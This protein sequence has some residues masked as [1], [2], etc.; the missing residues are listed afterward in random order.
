V[1]G[2]H[3][4]AVE[5]ADDLDADGEHYDG[6]EITFGMC[7]PKLSAT[8]AMPIMMRKPGA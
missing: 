5:H 3:T 6:V 1:K 4:A 7:A 2:P 8:N